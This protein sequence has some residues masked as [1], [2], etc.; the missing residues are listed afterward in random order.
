MESGSFRFE[1]NVK[2]S[3]IALPIIVNSVY[4]SLSSVSRKQC[5]IQVNIYPLEQLSLWMVDMNSGLQI[6]IA[7]KLEM[8]VLTSDIL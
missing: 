7:S 2:S 8:Y 3:L 6:E 1:E 4:S 5:R